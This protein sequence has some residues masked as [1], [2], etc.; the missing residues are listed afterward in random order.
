VF[1]GF[2]KRTLLKPANGLITFDFEKWRQPPFPENRSGFWKNMFG[3]R[4]IFHRN[5]V[6]QVDEF[7]WQVLKE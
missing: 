7:F 1:P 5:F 6:G 2:I 3:I 4:P